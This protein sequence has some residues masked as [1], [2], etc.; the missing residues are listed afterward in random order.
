M[1]EFSARDLRRKK[2][3]K[4]RWVRTIYVY[5]SMT[6]PLLSLLAHEACQ[7]VMNDHI[8]GSSFDR[9]WMEYK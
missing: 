2:R 5:E 9:L 4:Y 6:T 3:S 8:N 1:A 7:E